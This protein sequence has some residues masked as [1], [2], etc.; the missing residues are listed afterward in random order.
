[1]KFFL[2]SQNFIISYYF[3]LKTPILGIYLRSIADY[4][5]SSTMF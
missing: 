3:F 4:C 5:V 1:M 2:L